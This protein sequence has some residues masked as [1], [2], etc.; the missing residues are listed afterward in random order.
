MKTDENALLTSCTLSGTFISDEQLEQ[1]VTQTQRYAP[2]SQERQLALTRLVDEILRSRKVARPPI[3]QP[4]FGIY[5]EIYKQV[6]QQLLDDISKDFDNYNPTCIPVRAWVNNKR[7]QTFRKI[8]DDEQLKNMAIEA[9]R[10]PPN[11]ELRQYALGELVEA[12][13]L[14]GKLAHPHQ[15]RFSSPQFYELLYEEAVNKTLTY[16]CRKIHTYDPERGD[17]KFMNWVNFRLFSGRYTVISRHQY[18]ECQQTTFT[19]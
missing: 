14:S 3:G 10:Y 6:R 9:Q 16:V 4:L 13:R 12:I 15:K 19:H 7:N 2:Q 1:L 8:L 5:Q 17:K 11:T 18:S